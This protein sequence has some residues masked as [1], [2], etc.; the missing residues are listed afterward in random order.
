MPFTEGQLINVSTLVN[1]TLT[2]LIISFTALGTYRI[3][4]ILTK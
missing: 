1:V 3:K 2:L 4:H